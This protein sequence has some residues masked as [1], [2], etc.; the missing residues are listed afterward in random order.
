MSLR[1]YAYEKCDTCRKALKFLAAKKIAPEVIPIRDQPPTVPE[2]RAMLGHV[3]GDLRQ[4]FNTAGQDYRALD[5]KTRLPK[6]TVDEALA[7]LAS[8]GNLVKRPFAL[9]KK[10]GVTGFREEEWE[11]L[12]A[13]E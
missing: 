12:V 1:V 9:S 6:L 2:L 8:N 10:A 7:L 11:R 13:G 3:G 5:M 4:L